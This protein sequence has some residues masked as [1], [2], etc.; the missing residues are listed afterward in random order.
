MER[1]RWFRAF[2]LALLVL[3]F[4]VALAAQS[5]D[6]AAIQQKLNTQ[7]KLT[8]TTA[9]RS[10]LERS[11]SCHGITRPVKGGRNVHE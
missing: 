9:D 8:T 1:A 2:G 6:L 10:D 3:M 5:G 11:H 4:S 7:F